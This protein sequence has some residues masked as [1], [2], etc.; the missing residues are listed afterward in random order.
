MRDPQETMRHGERME[1]TRTTSSAPARA[2]G[3]STRLVFAIISVIALVAT[4]FAAGPFQARAAEAQAGICNPST[5]TIGDGHGAKTDNDD[6][7]ATWVGRDMYV[8][9]PN[10]S[11]TTTYN[12]DTKPEQSF[13]VEAEGLTVVNGKLALHGVKGKKNGK[14][15]NAEGV[16]NANFNGHGFRFGTVGFGAN[17]RPVKAADVLVVGG[18]NSAIS[19]TDNN[20][21]AVNVLAWGNAARGYVRSD[22]LGPAHNARIKSTDRTPS[23]AY[24]INYDDNYDGLERNPNNQDEWQVS[25][26]SIFN[27]DD[28]WN[29][30]ENDSTLS[31]V[32]WDN[33]DNPLKYVQLNHAWV[34]GHETFTDLSGYQNVVEQT[35]AVLEARPATAQGTASIAPAQS[36]FYRQNYGNA[37]YKVTFNFGGENSSTPK[38]RLITFT[39]NGTRT[40][41]V[42]SATGAYKVTGGSVMQV[43]TLDASLL[44]NDNTNGVS[45]RFDNIPDTASVVVNVIG[46]TESI[47]FNNGWRFWWNDA[48]ISNYY[49]VFDQENKR[50]RNDLYS[51][52]AS[53]LMWNFADAQK[54]TI[55]GGQ[56][57]NG[58]NGKVENTRKDSQYHSQNVGGNGQVQI[59]DDP[60]AN[61]L[62]S[63][64]VPKG[65]LETHVSTNGRVWVGQDYMMYNPIGLTDLAYLNGFD[66]NGWHEPISASVIE[67]DQERHNFGWYGEISDACAVLE[68]VK[69]DNNGNALAGTEWAVYASKEAAM[70]HDTTRA[71]VTVIDDGHDDWAIG[72][73]GE[74]KGK[75]SVRRLNPN[76]TYYLREISTASGYDL[77]TNIYEISTG[78]GNHTVDNIDSVVDGGF[79]QPS[80]TIDR[81]YTKDGEKIAPNSSQN[82]LWTDSSVQDAKPAVVNLPLPSVEWEKVDGETQAALG[83]SEWKLYRKQVENDNTSYPVIQENIADASGTTVYLDT[84]TAQW[85]ALEETEKPEIKISYRIEGN[86]IWASEPMRLRGDGIYSVELPSLGKQIWFSFFLEK[87]SNEAPQYRPGAG[88]SQDHFICPETVAHI[89]VRAKDKIEQRQPQAPGLAAY[90][91]LDSRIGRFQIG[92][93]NEGE[94]VLQE[95]KAPAGYWLS[96]SESGRYYTFTVV[97]QDGQY[98]ISWSASSITVNGQTI[99]TT[100]AITVNGSQVGSISNIPTKVKWEKV[101]SDNTSQHLAGSTWTLKQ[102]DSTLA[103]IADCTSASC[104]TGVYEDQD[105][106]EG[107]FMLK[108][109]PAGTY[110]LQEA[111]APEGYEIS[112]TEYA[113]TIH[114]T[115]PN[116]A[117]V[118]VNGSPIGN[119][120]KTGKVQ[121][122]KVAE[123]DSTGAKPL[124]G[125]EWQITFTPQGQGSTASQS[126]AIAD[127]KSDD[128]C[129]APSGDGA[130]AWAYDR[131][132]LGGKFELGNL[133]WG[134]Y[135]LTETKAPDGYNISDKTYTFT[136]DKNHLEN[137]E[138]KVDNTK[139]AGNLIA[140]E[141]GVVLPVTGAEGR[142]LWPAIVGAIF[143]LAAFGCA[144]MLRMRE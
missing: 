25:G 97:L 122:T 94:Y 105:S 140:N 86:N 114:Q 131:D 133:P 27:F 59:V 36:G 126:H 42:D 35:S 8:G 20:N 85:S 102:N 143:V 5:G 144:M 53:A 121:W 43:F 62:G 98:R 78:S 130:T 104:G 52:A 58:Q 79:A 96:N 32:N 6:G 19:L 135:V 10:E 50:A 33:S 119:S 56:I 7:V 11:G 95:M 80:T 44:N 83:G 118:K 22:S 38:E 1:H 91:D 40:N 120:R 72:T 112:T 45:F 28:P 116:S 71:L 100:Q 84:K 31:Y 37:G 137:I 26:D 136:I 47:D 49:T 111:S 18:N 75:F 129:S 4:M 89:T 51:H 127:C 108:R 55:R 21:K 70:E 60:V 57:T 81:V 65:S 48:E 93:L 30:Y 139:L 113:F 17:L 88:T 16:D 124:D 67:Q 77:N 46:D 128:E 101:D 13:A 66:S 3:A 74:G 64:M 107:K 90:V 106:A 69:V 82:L 24:E 125:S 54:V 63:I 68:W 109:L 41:E 2:A 14:E 142:H 87:D 29:K 138:I 12:K 132:K 99:Q 15:N 73:N 117:E 115:E 134:D 34:E 39:G 123:G 103:T 23:R 61:M 92:G 9:A 141:P 110:T 76:A